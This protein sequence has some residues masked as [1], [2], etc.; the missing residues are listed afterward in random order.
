MF[1]T[2]LLLVVVVVVAIRNVCQSFDESKGR[3]TYKSQPP[4]AHSKRCTKV[5]R[6]M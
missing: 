6:K 4:A 3:P 1:L 5:V 2:V